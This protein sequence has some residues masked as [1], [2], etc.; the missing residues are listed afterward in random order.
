MGFRQCGRRDRFR[1][2][3]GRRENRS[4][5]EDARNAYGGGREFAMG[6]MYALYEGGLSAEEIAQAGVRAA[7]EF[8]ESTAL[9]VT[10]RSLHLRS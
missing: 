6:A 9:P 4:R 10:S 7:A 5:T 2:P 8:D 1:P 3:G